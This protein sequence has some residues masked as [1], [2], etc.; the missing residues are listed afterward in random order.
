M[1]ED[2]EAIDLDIAPLRPICR[3]SLSA[4][5]PWDDAIAPGLRRE[6]WCNVGHQ[7]WTTSR[8]I[9]PDCPFC[10]ENRRAEAAANAE[11]DRRAAEKRRAEEQERLER[12]YTPELGLEADVK[13][14]MKCISLLRNS[15]TQVCEVEGCNHRAGVI[16]KS[17]ERLCQPE[18]ENYIC[19]VHLR[20][21]FY[22]P[23]LLLSQTLKEI[24]LVYGTD[25]YSRVDPFGF[26]TPDWT[27]MVPAGNIEEGII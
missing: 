6:T 16:V 26:G 23:R 9:T 17:P 5:A 1:I 10:L 11:E 18:V 12:A 2:L 7:F 20:A 14:R 22:L 19:V 24:G 27:R 8:D 25:V 3:V 15:G 4:R 21:H 13:S